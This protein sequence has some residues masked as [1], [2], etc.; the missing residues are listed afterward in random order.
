[1]FARLL[2]SL[3]VLLFVTTPAMADRPNLILQITVDQLRGDMLQR[4]EH[5]FGE[6]GL[7]YLLDNGTVYT[8]ARFRH[9]NTMTAVGHATLATGGNT[10]QHGI[11]ANDWYDRSLG[12]TIYALEDPASPYIGAEPGA[13][14][15]RSPRNLTSSTFAD[16]LVLASG[17]KSRAF[18][19]STKDRGAII[20]AGRRGLAYWYSTM[21]G[22]FVSTTWYQAEYPGWVQAWNARELAASYAGKTWGLLQPEAEYVFAGQDDR[23]F[24]KPRGA[25]G[26][27]FP[28]TM[29]GEV[30]GRWFSDLRYTPWMDEL[31]LDFARALIEAERVG[32]GGHTDYLA[33]SFS[34]TDYIG[35][36]YGPNSLETEDNLL[37]LDRVIARLL[38]MVD[39]AVGLANTVVVLSAD[40][41]IQAAPEHLAGQ[42]FTAGRLGADEL[43]GILDAKMRDHFDTDQRLVAAFVK[44]SVYLDLDALERAGIDVVAAERQLAR[45]VT[46]I[47]GFAHAFT[48]SALL[49]GAVPDTALTRA[50]LNAFHPER[51]GNVYVVPESFWL[52]GSS[53]RSDA[54]THGT[55]HAADVHVPLVFTGPGIAH[56]T[57]H[58]RVAPRDV[59]P[60]LSAIMGIL[61][62]SGATGEVLVEV[63]AE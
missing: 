16:E 46:A 11:A 4:F 63:V 47:P 38:R 35:H 1:M 18:G 59:A 32:Q 19:V 57:V 6:G 26:R 21:T 48:R 52:F 53:A 61:R 20:P 23:P 39:E 33:V 29:A 8:D 14:G 28:H 13:P 54:A 60:T 30:G 27:T 45:E 24:E 31:T 12:R 41:G 3:I 25:L 22:G 10:P 51:S 7:R 15:G 36:A 44:P 40:H 5:R 34:A 2:I 37:R 17:G 56:R 62:P 42:G 58:R 55:P 50:V 43:L 9:A 49:V